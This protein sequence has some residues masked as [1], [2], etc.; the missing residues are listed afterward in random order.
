MPNNTI[1]TRRRVAPWV[2]IGVSGRW[3]NSADALHA[4]E[5]D[6]IVRQE[7]LFWQLDDNGII[8]NEKAPMYGNVRSTDNQ[9]LG[10]VTPQYKIIQN[11]DAFALLD[12]F[13]GND[14]IITH[15]GMTE[16]GLCF[17]VAEVQNRTIGGEEYTINLMATNSFNTKYP[18]QI[19]M[20]PVRIICQNMYRKLVPDRIFATKHTITANDKLKAIASGNVVEKKVLAFTDVIEFAQ[21][22]AMSAAKLNLLISML[23]PYPKEGGPRETTFKLKADEQRQKFLD[24]YYDAPDNRCHHD[25]AFGFINAYYDYLSH[26]EA[27]RNTSV[28]WADRRLSGMVSE[29]DIKPSLLKEVMR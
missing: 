18:C 9:L 3:D 8:Y 23:F 6:F 14:G 17:M 28:A 2:G 25:T 7:Q 29:D 10:C 24:Q 26:R 19:I 22:K 16:D 27:V 12:P 15:A 21:G 13:L 5:L 1:V 11:T 4:A 20:T